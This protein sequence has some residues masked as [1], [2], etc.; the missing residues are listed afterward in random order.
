MF[1]STV[2]LL[3]YTLSCDSK[4]VIPTI[5][6]GLFLKFS[7]CFYLYYKKRLVSPSVHHT[8]QC[9]GEGKIDPKT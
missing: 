1:F 7:V 3:P 9:D 2:K 4:T 6:C 5:F 8:L